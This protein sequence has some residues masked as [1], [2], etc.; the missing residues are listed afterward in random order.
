MRAYLSI[1]VIASLAGFASLL[2]CDSDPDQDRSVGQTDFESAPPKGGGDGRL[3]GE[4]SAG[5]PPPSAPVPPAGD[6]PGGTPRT[7]EETDLYRLDGTR[8]YYL[9]S[10]RGLMVFDV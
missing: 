7:V 8:L 10:Y 6:A 9:N 5:V 3:A 2:G 1:P 4:D